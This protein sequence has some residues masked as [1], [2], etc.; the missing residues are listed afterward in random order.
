MKLHYFMML[1]LGHNE[2]N[3]NLFSSLSGL[4]LKCHIKVYYLI[5]KAFFIR[6]DVS[7]SD[8]TITLMLYNRT[9]IDIFIITSLFAS[10]EDDEINL[11]VMELIFSYYLTIPSCYCY[12]PVVSCLTVN[13]CQ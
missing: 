10:Q 1:L 5:K 13:N 12:M 2:Y 6:D 3:I 9:Y 7:Y 4:H 8:C 11:L